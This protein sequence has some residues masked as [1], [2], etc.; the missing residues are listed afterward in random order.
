MTDKIKLLKEAAADAAE[1]AYKLHTNGLLSDPN[2]YYLEKLTKNVDGL[3]GKI[4]AENADAYRAAEEIF[5]NE[6]FD[7]IE[8]IEEARA[9][10]AECHD[11]GD[12]E[13]Y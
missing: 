13:S 2:E 1:T 12:Y 11:L 3:I 4:C 6:Y 8:N 9:W 10:E 7:T 5:S